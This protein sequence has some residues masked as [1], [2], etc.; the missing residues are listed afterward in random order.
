MSERAR[1][2]AEA[3]RIRAEIEQLFT[4]AVSWND[5]VRRPGE[6]PIDP[7]D[8]VGQLRHIADGLDRM[9]AAEGRKP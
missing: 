8:P 7:D 2:I 5:N 6:L 4:D 1:I 9:L 3:R